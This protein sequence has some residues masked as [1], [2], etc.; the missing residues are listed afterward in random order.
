M[1]QHV[2]IK[3]NTDKMLNELSEKRKNDEAFIKSKQD[4]VAQAVE[5]IYRK[6]IKAQ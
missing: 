2:K 5:A 4:I 1:A 3:P 6:E